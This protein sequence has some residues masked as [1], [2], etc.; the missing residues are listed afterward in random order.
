MVNWRAENGHFEFNLT[1]ADAS[2]MQRLTLSCL[3]SLASF[4]FLL[5][6]LS[7]ADASV[8]TFGTGSNQFDMTFVEIGNPNNPGDT[9][10]KPNPAGS[11]AYKYQMGKYEVSEGMIDKF[12][13]SQSLTI[14]PSKPNSPRRM[15]FCAWPSRQVGR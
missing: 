11:V 8:T 15:P 14:G 13:A 5:A 1:P 12:N 3:I 10:G 7:D 2:V 9:T 4:S 6:L